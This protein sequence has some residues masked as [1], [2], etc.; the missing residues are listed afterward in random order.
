MFLSAAAASLMKVTCRHDLAFNP[1]RIKFEFKFMVQAVSKAQIV[2]SICGLLASGE[3]L[4]L[5]MCQ[6][7]CSAAVK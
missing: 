5:L 2:L 4:I 3:K 1:D 7:M 6:S